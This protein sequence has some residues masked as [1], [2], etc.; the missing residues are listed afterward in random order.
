MSDFFTVHSDCN[1]DRLDALLTA[2]LDMLDK[3]IQALTTLLETSNPFDAGSEKYNYMRN[4]HHT[5]GTAF[6]R[7]KDTGLSAADVQIAKDRRGE[8]D[9]HMPAVSPVLTMGQPKNRLV[10]EAPQ[11]SLDGP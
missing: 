9:I 1:T 11:Q 3:T 7:R 10:P 8:Q 5:F 6:Y 4:L 2:T